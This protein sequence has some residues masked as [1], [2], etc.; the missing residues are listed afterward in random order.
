MLYD[1]L[2]ILTKYRMEFGPKQN[3]RSIDLS[4]DIF[5]AFYVESQNLSPEFKTAKTLDSKG[6][7]V[8]RRDSL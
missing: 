5:K 1:Y 7:P 4:R 2:N 8:L 3:W 6:C